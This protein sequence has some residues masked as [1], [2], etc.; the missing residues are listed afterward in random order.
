M[1]G[2]FETKWSAE[3]I[4]SF[5]QLDLGAV[6]K[7]CSVDVS[8]FEGD[9]RKNDFILSISEDGSAF[10]DVLRGSSSGTTQAKERYDFSPANARYLKIAFYGNSD[11]EDHVTVRELAVNTMSTVKPQNIS[12]L[13][14]ITEIKDRCLPHTLAIT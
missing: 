1:D 8:W 14:D 12:G 7:L 9:E 13:G 3:D 5:L 11:N 4:G 6:K 2:D 10:K